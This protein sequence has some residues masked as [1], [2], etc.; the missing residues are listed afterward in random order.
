[1]TAHMSSG[2]HLW[3]SERGR[4][5]H[6]PVCS[7]M[8]G[9]WEGPGGRLPSRCS[10]TSGIFT[11]RQGYIIVFSRLRSASCLFGFVFPMGC[12]MNGLSA[13]RRRERTCHWCPVSRRRRNGRLK[14]VPER[15]LWSPVGERCSSLRIPWAYPPAEPQTI[16]ARFCWHFPTFKRRFVSIVE[17]VFRE[18]APLCPA[19][20]AGQSF[21]PAAR[22][23]S[24][25][26]SRRSAQVG[27]SLSCPSSRLR[28]C[29][30]EL[31]SR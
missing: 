13:R 26:V 5:G 29:R 22:R 8:L 11:L 2:R 12:A 10:L 24:S 19:G 18:M 31:P 21:A 9:G 1:M 28:M 7:V 6:L 4:S 3:L 27:Y 23:A 30:I 16:I 20:L 25:A 15:S 14:G 17:F